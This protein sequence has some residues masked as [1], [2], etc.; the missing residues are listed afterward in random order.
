MLVI[1]LTD[2]DYK[3]K[4]LKVFLDGSENPADFKRL[5]SDVKECL[6]KALDEIN[7]V[8]VKELADRGL[9]IFPSQS[10]KSDLDDG[11]KTILTV[12]HL[13]S[14][15]P[16]IKTSNIM[17][18]FS[19]GGV[20][21]EIRSRFDS[22][23]Q[24]FFLHYMLQKFCNAAPTI[25]PTDAKRDKFYDFIVYLFPWYLKKAVAQGLFRAYIRRDYND[26]NIRGT[27]DFPRHFRY[28]IPFNGKIA[29]RTREYSHDNSITQLVRHTIEF[30][31]E[32][33]NLR[34]ILAVDKEMRDA[35][36]LIRGSTGTYSRFS[37]ESVIRQNLRTNPHPYYTEYEPLR[38]LCISILTHEKL[39]FGTDSKNKLSGILFDGAALWE[40]YIYTILKDCDFRHP[41]NKE[42]KGGRRMFLKPEDEDY[43][44]NNSRRLYPDFWKDDFIIDAKYKHLEKG[45]GREDLYQVVTYMHCM[46]AEKGGFI[47]PTEKN[48]D[49][50][51]YELNG[52][53]GNIH[54]IGIQIP[55]EAD[56]GK[57]K[58]QMKNREEKI[59][60]EINQPSPK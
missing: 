59:R 34:G 47:F 28:N 39:S 48:E 19:V 43:F 10:A 23:D 30:I 20:R 25:E 5:S 6:R 54:V 4:P 12:Q 27:I 29:Y 33:H 52:C 26:S 44:D 21:F 42:S 16:T 58:D 31:A 32:N 45:V 7:N 41:K 49:P 53:G 17:G 8:S 3:G 22:G 37:R 14:D 1:K 50:K 51:I 9:I 56:W 36:Q 18:F 60:E 35:V 57:F 2:N 24:Q 11:K 13:T 55:R 15:E 40:E 46:E 38:K